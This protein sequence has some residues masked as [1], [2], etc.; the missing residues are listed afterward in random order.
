MAI[1]W[2]NMRKKELVMITTYDN[3]ENKEIVEMES[4]PNVAEA[5]V[6]ILTAVGI[7]A[8]FGVPGGQ[9]LP[10]YKAARARG[11]KHVLMR[12]ERNCA[13][14][15][16]AYARV[17]GKVGLCDATV[18]PG[19][20]NLVS[21][22]AEAYASSIPM[23]AL[24]A[25]INT[26]GEHLRHRGNVAQAL[27]QRPLLEPTTKWIGRVQKPDMLIDIMDHALRVATT[28]RPGP[29][30]IEIPEEVMLA[31]LSEPNLSRFNKDSAVWPRHRSA[32]PAEKVVDA[33]SRLT[34]ARRPIILAGGG[35]IASGAYQEIAQF[36]DKHGFPVVTSINGKGII[37]ERHPRAY[38]AIGIFGEIKASYALQQ[39]DVVL[40]LGS[41]FSQFNSFAWQL[42]MK[43][44]EVI[45]V[46]IDGEELGRAI[47]VAL[48]VVAD[49]RVAARQI[50]NGLKEN[51]AKFD[52]TPEGEVPKQPGTEIDDPAVAPEQVIASIGDLFP[53]DMILVSD[54][55]LSSGWTASRH[56]VQQAGRGYIAPRGIAGLGWACGAAIGVALAAP[57]G[58]RIVVVAGDGAA[59][60]WLG[61]IETAVRL[62]LPIT[63]VILNNAGFGWI[64]QC[65]RVMNF[66]SESTFAPVD[67]AAIGMAMGTGGARAKS[68]D[69]V[70]VGLRQAIDLNG[71]FVLDVLSSDRSTPT[72]DYG[73]LAPEAI[74]RNG[75]YGVG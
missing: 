32:A 3:Q 69:E 50:L 41:K 53:E 20:T 18:G 19:V 74:S 33:V 60:Y 11:F 26:C 68:M 8:C 66:T 23:I 14:A 52:W 7:D 49:V 72:V 15:A 57:E 25:D 12:D 73:L 10:F 35:A 56:K 45:H 5:I 40:V 44:Q 13:C 42:P 65:E 75:A 70:H 28:G 29:V 47:P 54:A 36:A 51:N 31:P 67:F 1:Y 9:T 62:N 37:D 43:T 71:P 46:D 58:K 16:D 64:V 48:E 59:A 4:Q 2:W 63:F 22:L 30:A 17:S 39:A 27:E 21:G 24:I 38:G 6:S 34:Q 61:E 55:S